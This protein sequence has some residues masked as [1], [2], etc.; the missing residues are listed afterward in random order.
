MGKN[1]ANFCVINRVNVNLRAVISHMPYGAGPS[2]RGGAGAESARHMASVHD[3]LA[4]SPGAALR[5]LTTTLRARAVVEVGT[6]SG[7]NALWMLRGMVDTG[8]VTSIDIDP[9]VQSVATRALLDAG[10]RRSQLR[11]ITG[12]PTQVLPRLTDGGYDL[13]LVDLTLRGGGA[14]AHTTYLELGARLLREGGVLVFHG[15]EFGSGE[16]RAVRDLTGA[17][18]EDEDLVPMA[19]PVGDGMLAVARASGPRP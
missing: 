9:A 5:F 10:V 2:G 16:D 15:P 8:V 18:G 3:P 4:P 19:L 14:A 17:L 11:M 7:A 12:V 6:G 1:H 13:V